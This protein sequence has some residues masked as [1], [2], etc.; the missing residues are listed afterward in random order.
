MVGR[1]TALLTDLGVAEA[2]WQETL[3][4]ASILE[5]EASVPEDL[6]KVARVI[7]NRLELPE[8]ET[9]GLLQMDSTVL[10]GVGKSGGLP[11]ADDLGSDSPYNTYRVQGLPPTPIA[12][13][14]QAAIEA[15]INPADGDWLYFVT[16]NLDTGE[17]LFSSTLAE[18]TSNIELLNKWCEQNEG[19]C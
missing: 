19:R 12:T 6:S 10:Y 2:D 15:T 1:T 13:P 11:T 3:I 7:L 16:V 17:T 9:R 5:R 18:Q 8:A 4:K 14:S